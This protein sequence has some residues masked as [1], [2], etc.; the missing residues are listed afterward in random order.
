MVWVAQE[1]S[2]LVAEDDGFLEQGD[3]FIAL[4]SC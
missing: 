4:S 3:I 2:C 1:P